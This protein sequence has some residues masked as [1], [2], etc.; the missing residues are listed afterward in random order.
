MLKVR[1]DFL[2][3]TEQN[4]H[5]IIDNDYQYQIN[6]IVARYGQPSE[7]T[8]SHGIGLPYWIFEEQGFTIDFETS[9]WD[10]TVWNDFAGSTP[11][12]IHIGSTTAEMLSA[13]LKI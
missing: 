12:G 5:S 3:S 13:L 1:H 9:I 8:L 11:R 4:D 6:H 7:K 10:I 2:F